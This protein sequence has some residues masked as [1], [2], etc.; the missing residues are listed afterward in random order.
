MWFA[1]GLITLLVGFTV[2]LIARSRAG[3]KGTPRGSGDAP[4]H[5]YQEVFH[6]KRLTRVRIGMLAPKGLEFR[7]RKERWHDRFFKSI[8]ISVEMQ[9]QD[10]SFD[11][12]VYLESDVE[13]LGHLLMQNLELRSA[14]VNIFVRADAARCKS[15]LIRCSHGRIWI[16]LAPR[17]ADIGRHVDA[18][19]QWLNVLAKSLAAQR[20]M[21]E[22]QQDPF[23]GRAILVLSI[24][25]AT[26]IL[27]VYGLIRGVGGRTDILDSWGLFAACVVPGLVALG[28]FV[29]TIITFLGRS[30]RTHLV[31]VEAVLVGGMGFVVG[32]FALARELNIE[33]DTKPADVIELGD[34]RA[35]HKITRGRR[36]RQNHHYYLHVSDWRESKRSA[37]LR[38]EISSDLYRQL[39]NENR[40]ALGV[41]PGL[42]GF[43]WI[44]SIRPQRLE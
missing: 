9:V 31:L 4:R 30:S 1:F 12:A 3:W 33:F 40:V 16:E 37:P 25:T 15:V 38:L 24:S 36:G 20:A 10:S 35:E 14:I 7:V 6:K 28:F 23:V 5:E 18:F 21:L 41:K 34:V 19:A 27:G 39:A 43:E 42:L 8:G 17:D 11:D 2:S 26:A 29:A 22:Q 13:A 32:L 44:E